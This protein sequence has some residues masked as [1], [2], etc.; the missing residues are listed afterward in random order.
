MTIPSCRF[1]IFLPPLEKTHFQIFISRLLL[2]MGELLLRSRWKYACL[3][4]NW[5]VIQE[6]ICWTY[7][8]SAIYLKYWPNSENFYFLL[9]WN[10][11]SRKFWNFQ[12]VKFQKHFFL[13]AHS[14][15]FPA[16]YI[17]CQIWSLSFEEENGFSER[18]CGKF[19]FFL[20]IEKIEYVSI[21]KCWYWPRNNLIYSESLFPFNTFNNVNSGCWS[22]LLVF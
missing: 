6:K 11:G 7:A 10:L 12:L 15:T 18:G 5:I 1:Y 3:K 9:N 20:Q 4:G 16:M 13:I 19:F 2:A 21:K 8:W 22:V 14:L 17:L